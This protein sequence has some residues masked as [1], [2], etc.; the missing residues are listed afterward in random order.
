MGA[1]L[2][3]VDP[4]DKLFMGTMEGVRNLVNKWRSAYHN[5]ATAH[6]DLA[7]YISKVAGNIRRKDKGVNLGANLVELI[8]YILGFEPFLTWLNDPV[9]SLHIGMVTQVFDAFSNIPSSNNTKRLL[10]SVYTSSWREGV[11]KTWIDAFYFSL[12]SMLTELGMT[13]EED[14]EISYP[15]GMIPIMTIHQS[16]GLEFP[17]VFVHG[18]S[19]WDPSTD[20]ISFERLLRSESGVQVPH[21]SDS[22]I[23]DM[24]SNDVARMFFVAYS[25]AQNALIILAQKQDRESPGIGCGGSGWSVF[26]NLIRIRG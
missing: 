24:A 14:E 20:D 13:E 10:G 26:R 1:F 11:S 8:Y 17:F 19:S 22:D 15:P 3:L 7:N 18:L 12:I 4:E 25:R 9:R 5:A 23:K 21:L 2:H 6:R 16:K